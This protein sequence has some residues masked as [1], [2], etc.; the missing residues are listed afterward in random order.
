MRLGLRRLGTT[1]LILSALAVLVSGCG[2]S[3]KTSQPT[4]GTTKASGPAA[5]AHLTAALYRAKLRRIKGEVNKA[6]ASIRS[7]FTQAKSVSDLHTA[8]K[9]LAH[10]EIRLSQEVGKLR[11]PTNAKAA[12]ALLAKGF[13]DTAKQIQGV[14]PQISS[15]KSPQAAIGI[16]RHLQSTGGTEIGRAV[17]QLKRLGYTSGS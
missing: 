9:G 15:A 5:Q 11:A 4:G 14:L 12:N 16:L 8:L 13:A 17:A 7:S 10:E 3:S 1:A 6:Q 2:S